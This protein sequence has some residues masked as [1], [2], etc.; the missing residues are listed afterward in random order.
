[1]AQARRCRSAASVLTRVA[2][3][4]PAPSAGLRALRALRLLRGARRTPVGR[5]AQ[6]AVPAHWPHQDWPEATWTARG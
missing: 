2:S 4:P 1:M 6:A 3:P 5:G